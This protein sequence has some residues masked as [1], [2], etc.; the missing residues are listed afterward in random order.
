[1]FDRKSD[2]FTGF[3]TLTKGRPPLPSRFDDV[4]ISIYVLTGAETCRLVKNNRKLSVSFESY[5]HLKFRNSN[6][7]E[8]LK[9]NPRFF[10]SGFRNGHIVK[11]IWG[12]CFSS[13]TK[14]PFLLDSWKKFDANWCKIHLYNQWAELLKFFTTNSTG[15]VPKKF[16]L[17]T[18]FHVD[19]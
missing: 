14:D 19:P 8:D 6:G 9:K 10:F 7:A 13:S 15:K 12:V 2:N 3:S 16:F 4:P 1:M 17:T 5:D 11:S 18:I